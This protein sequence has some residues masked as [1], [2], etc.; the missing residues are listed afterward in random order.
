MRQTLAVIFVCTALFILPTKP[1]ASQTLVSDVEKFYADFDTLMNAG[2]HEAIVSMINT[3]VADDFGHYDDGVRTYG[4]E[5]FITITRN[6]PQDKFDMKINIDMQDVKHDPEGNEIKANF[7]IK[8]DYF[9]RDTA[10]KLMASMTLKCHDSL[11][12]TEENNFQLYKCDCTTLQSK[13]YE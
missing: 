1:H 4:K 13:R 9:S 5:E 8:Q 11:R 10:K 7:I 6:V 2:E 3:H 12:I